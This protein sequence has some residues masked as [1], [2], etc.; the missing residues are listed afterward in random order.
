MPINVSDIVGRISGLFFHPK[1]HS[2]DQ[3]SN[4]EPMPE[5][6]GLFTWEGNFNPYQRVDIPKC[7]RRPMYPQ[8]PKD[9]TV[10]IDVPGALSRTYSNLEGKPCPVNPF[11]Q[12]VV[13]G[14]VVQVG[15][16]IQ[17]HGGART[18]TM[19]QCYCKVCKSLTEHY[20]RVL[21]PAHKQEWTEWKEEVTQFKSDL[22]TWKRLSASRKEAV[23]RLQVLKL[24]RA[25]IRKQEQMDN[26]E[27]RR[28]LSRHNN[29]MSRASS[30][31]MES[32]MRR[33]GFIGT[34]KS[35]RT[36]VV[37]YRVN[38]QG[39]RVVATISPLK[40]KK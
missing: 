5:P 26:V 27:M 17:L 28:H 16:H 6:N 22:A 35:G 32:V 10:T 30:T 18:D 2:P 15:M 12:K 31:T 25:Q 11:V 13:N 21:K 4:A 37:H 40:A 7:P 14:Q 29:N 3:D 20:H 23:E 36:G 34:T 9:L 24:V 19:K 33:D 8:K 38:A 1:L 39:E